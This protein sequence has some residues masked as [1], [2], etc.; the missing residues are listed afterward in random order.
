M[1]CSSFFFSSR[2]RHTRCEL[3][4][5]VQTCARPICPLDGVIDA[6]GAKNAA[7]P[8]LCAS[9][10]SDEPLHV[11]NVPTLWDINTT[12][13]LPSQ[14]ACTVAAPALHELI[15]DAPPITTCVAPSETV[16]PLPVS[17]L[18]LG[19]LVVRRG[20]AHV[21]DPRGFAAGARPVDPPMVGRGR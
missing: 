17:A 1:I 15:V 4:T 5:G 6:S 19:P 3:V 16:R 2:R 20:E 14:M 8:I 13:K 7:L 11:T 12:R 21:C 9:L 10:L 18:V